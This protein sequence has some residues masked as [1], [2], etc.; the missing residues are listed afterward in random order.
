M[1]RRT[2]SLAENV[3]PVKLYLDDVDAIV[4]AMQAAGEGEVTVTTVDHVLRSVE[5][6]ERYGEGVLRDVEIQRFNPYVS[7]HLRGAG[8]WIYTATDEPV[9][10]GVYYKILALVARRRR[11][12]GWLTGSSWAWVVGGV[13]INVGAPL[14]YATDS[15]PLIAFGAV[16]L[17]LGLVTLIAS[18]VSVSR[19][20]V[21]VPARKRD[22]PSFFQ[23]NTDRLIIGITGAV[24]GAVIAWALGQL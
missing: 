11:R 19:G 10:T 18:L 24:V 22:A 8:A 9:S 16:L 4:Q 20:A 2:K 14:I 17:I 3:T 12:V 23:R 13:L 15:S 5:E 7:V 21:L 1:E 6:L